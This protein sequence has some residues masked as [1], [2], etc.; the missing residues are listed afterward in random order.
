M[1]FVIFPAFFLSTA[2]YP[3]WKMAESSTL[4]RD[5]C[6][7]NPFSQAVES[8]RFALYLEANW[9]ALTW[10]AIAFVLFFAISLWGYDPAK[11]LI[12]RKG[13]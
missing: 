6:A 2:L 11:G 5:I 7:A 10:T 9:T 12:V 4:L 8:I 1:N 3:L 13:G